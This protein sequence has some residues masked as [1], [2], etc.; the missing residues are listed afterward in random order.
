MHKI[1]LGYRYIHKYVQLCSFCTNSNN[2]LIN[3]Q[4]LD[5]HARAWVLQNTQLETTRREWVVT[6]FYQDFGIISTQVSLNFLHLI[7]WNT[8]CC[9]KYLKRLTMSRFA[10]PNINLIFLFNSNK[11]A[12]YSF[13]MQ[14][15]YFYMSTSDFVELNSYALPLIQ[16]VFVC[17]II[18]VNECLLRLGTFP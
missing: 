6:F 8:I 7:L 3:Y 11:K 12:Y 13:S 9:I 15:N 1:L 14:N 2:K 5:L 10:L 16:C 18:N 17:Q 4:Q